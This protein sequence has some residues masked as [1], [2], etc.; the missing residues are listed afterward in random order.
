M[1][2]IANILRNPL[3]MPEIELAA[4][5]HWGADEIESLRTQLANL[6]WDLATAKDALANARADVARLQDIVH[7]REAI[8]KLNTDQMQ[9]DTKLIK[10]LGVDVMLLREALIGLEDATSNIPGHHGPSVWHALEDARQAL[11]QTKP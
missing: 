5:R 11:E 7:G 6:R 9:R 4:A 8:D 3:G 1:T 10:R 2:D